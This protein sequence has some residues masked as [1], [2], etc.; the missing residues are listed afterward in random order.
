[1]ATNDK[2]APLIEVIGN[3]TPHNDHD[4]TL[5]AIK[6]SSNFIWIARR[7]QNHQRDEPDDI[8]RYAEEYYEK[9]Q[10]EPNYDYS[11]YDN[12]DVHTIS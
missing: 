8:Y 1:M 3:D 12:L 10:D 9:A 2:L 11:D 5:P 7:Y 4:Q 6:E